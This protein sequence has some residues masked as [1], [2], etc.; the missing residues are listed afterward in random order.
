VVFAATATPLFAAYWSTETT[1]RFQSVNVLNAVLSAALLRVFGVDTDRFATVLQFKHSGMEIIS[2][3]SGIY[4]A[5]L[6]ASGVL[7][8]PTTWRARLAGVLLGV[9]A[10][11]AINWLAWSPWEW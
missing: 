7:A 6:F 1:G 9:A 8:F 11:F 4:V 10:I 5:I 2:E 3:C